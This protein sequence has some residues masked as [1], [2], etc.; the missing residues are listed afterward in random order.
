MSHPAR[1]AFD[2]ETLSV[3]RPGHGTSVTVAYRLRR[4]RAAG[5][6]RRPLLL[7]LH[8]S[9]ERGTC[10]HAQLAHVPEHLDDADADAPFD[11]FVLAPQCAPD[12]R[13][14]EA[15]WDALP[16]PAMDDEPSAMMADV[17]AILDHVLA[18]ENVDPT[19]VYLTGLSMGGQGAWELAIRRP[20]TFAALVPIC[21]GADPARV[22]AL[23]GLPVW[24]WHGVDDDAV[25]FARTE[26]MVDALRAAGGDVRFER[27]PEGTGHAAWTP[28]YAA[29][30]PL[31]RWL[32]ERA[33]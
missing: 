26:L 8:G 3:P 9:G 24:A 27:L 23:A 18:T 25:P 4:P 6:T 16:P 14:V 11:G 17:L 12:H 5:G 13:W 7:C 21:G 33:R 1:P 15:S 30:G 29:T 28:A 10:N 32:A 2:A 22:G 19:R 31:W 20:G